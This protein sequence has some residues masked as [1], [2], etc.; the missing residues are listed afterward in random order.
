MIVKDG[1]RIV[2][3]PAAGPVTVTVTLCDV[4]DTEESVMLWALEA[5]VPDRA[6]NAPLMSGAGMMFHVRPPTVDGTEMVR[7]VTGFE[8]PFREPHPNRVGV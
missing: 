8:R 6:Q 4:D 1:L 5:T 7:I 3:E 2:V